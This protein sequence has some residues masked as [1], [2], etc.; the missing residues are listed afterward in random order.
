MACWVHGYAWVSQFSIGMT[1]ALGRT[2]FRSSQ[3]SLSL[4]LFDVLVVASLGML[5]DA[6]LC[7]NVSHH[8]P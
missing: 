7:P 5:V 4:C 2:A 6:Q 3:R 8:T 1:N